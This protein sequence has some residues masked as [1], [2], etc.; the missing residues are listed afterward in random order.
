MEEIEQDSSSYY[1]LHQKIALVSLLTKEMK[2]KQQQQE[3]SCSSAKKILGIIFSKIS[4]VGKL[5]F[6]S[7]GTFSCDS[8]SCVSS[9]VQ[10]KKKHR[11]ANNNN[12]NNT[13]TQT[14]DEQNNLLEFYIFDITHQRQVNLTNDLDD[15]RLLIF[16]NVSN[17]L[18]TIGIRNGK[19]VLYYI[20][21]VNQKKN[22]VLLLLSFCC[23]YSIKYTCH[24]H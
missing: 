15:K 16:Y 4:F 24:C 7:L 21:Y 18:Y 11:N 5:Y 1:R 8:L 10:S 14:A 3:F 9:N 13:T 6:I 22:I 17:D 20:L 19:F 23:L 2:Q 12:N